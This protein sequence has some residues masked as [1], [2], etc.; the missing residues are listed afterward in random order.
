MSGYIY[1]PYNLQ[2]AGTPTDVLA[3][4]YRP[5]Y[6]GGDLSGVLGERYNATWGTYAGLYKN[7]A[8][9]IFMVISPTVNTVANYFNAID[10]YYSNSGNGGLWSLTV[11][12]DGVVVPGIDPDTYYYTPLIPDTSFGINGDTYLD[13]LNNKLY[14]KLG[15][16]RFIET[17]GGGGGL[18]AISQGGTG[19]TSAAAAFAA[20][21][22]AP[23]IAGNQIVSNGTSWTVGPSAA[24]NPYAKP[25]IFEEFYNGPGPILSCPNGGGAIENALPGHPGIESVNTGTGGPGTVKYLGTQQYALV[26][27]D[28]IDTT[29]WE[30]MIPTLSDGTNTF[31]VECGTQTYE[32]L[33]PYDPNYGIYFKYRHDIN[34]GNWTA[35]SNDN[36]NP[37]YPWHVD[38][39]IPVVAGQWYRLTL[40]MNANA[41]S[42]SYYIDGVLVAT[43]TTHLPPAGAISGF[44]CAIR[45]ELGNTSRSVWVDYLY[46]EL[47]LTNPR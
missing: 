45:A 18:V 37:P 38:T 25:Y 12:A 42:A 14:Q 46:H 10:D 11:P 6:T 19:Q 32:Q 39:G 27:G 43:I 23:G 40:V 9:R 3:I 22:P 47:Q 36:S 30:I 33:L 7:G 1:C 20:L 8:S 44:M 4:E 41:T 34:G 17:L 16:W 21:A 2:A 29:E 13:L 5:G 26:W 15:I 28:G 24:F 31:T 35:G